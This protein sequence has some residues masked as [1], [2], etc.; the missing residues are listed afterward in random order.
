MEIQSGHIYTMQCHSSQTFPATSF[1]VQSKTGG[2]DDLYGNDYSKQS[3]IKNW[4]W[5]NP[6]AIRTRLVTELQHFYKAP[7][8]RNFKIITMI[9]PTKVCIAVGGC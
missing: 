7:D 5:R 2:K 1:E 9:S 6:I 8:H 4:R 3:I